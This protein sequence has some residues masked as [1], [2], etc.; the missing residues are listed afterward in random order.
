MY[1]KTLDNR[2]WVRQLTGLVLAAGL[3]VFAALP[4]RAAL[5]VYQ[6]PDGSRVITDRQMTDR[7]YRLLHRSAT[8]KHVG[9]WAAGRMASLTPGSPS[10]YDT[11]IR[12][13]AANYHLDPALIKAMIHVESAFDANAVSRKGAK[14]LMQLMPG[15]AR[16]YGV[17]NTF[18][19]AQNVYA[20]VRH[21]KDLLV[22]FDYN[23]RLALAAYNAGAN[24]V[25]QYRGVPP[26]AE[27]RD[28]VQKVQLLRNRYSSKYW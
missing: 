17:R 9:T 7:G 28:Y 13:A 26:Y 12:R 16:H 8:P 23:Y 2:L 21:F 5:Y 24:A 3:G 10:A 22:S 1:V 20:G 15:T 19:P 6:A 4:A 27:T 11:L 18:D 14:G 25:R